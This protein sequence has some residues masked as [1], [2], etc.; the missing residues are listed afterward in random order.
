M[1]LLR[2]HFLIQ[3]PPL[4]RTPR[5]SAVM[6]STSH[7]PQTRG[8]KRLLSSARRNPIAIVPSTPPMQSST[9][10]W[11][12]VFFLTKHDIR[13]TDI[14]PKDFPTKINA[15]FTCKGCKSTRENCPY[16]RPGTGKI[17]VLE[18]ALPFPEL[19]PVLEMGNPISS[20]GI[21]LHFCCFLALVRFSHGCISAQRS[22][23]LPNKK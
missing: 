14:F 18:M 2:L 16:V 15:D 10:S 23:H 4:Q 13:A 9:L 20:T 1:W 8:Q 6:Q 22:P 19:V 5:I 12:C 21:A 17:P 11:T 3:L 7:P